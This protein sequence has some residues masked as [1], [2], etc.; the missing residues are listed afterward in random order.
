MVNGM[1]VGPGEPEEIST[2]IDN[3]RSLFLRP[4][5]VLGGL[6]VPKASDV[7][8][9]ELRRQI[10]DGVLPEGAALP[11]ERDLAATSGLSRT[12]VREALRILEIDGLVQT[13]PGRAGGSFVRRPD[14]SSMARSVGA[15][16]AG[17]KVKFRALL[18]VREALEPAG[19][20]LAATYRDDDD[21]AELDNACQRL[22]ESFDDVSGFLLRNLEW[23]VAVVH[24]SHNDLMDAFIRSLSQAIL[25]GTEIEDFYS[26]TTRE[27]TA[28]AHRKVVAAIRDGDAGKARRTMTRHVHAYRVEVESREVPEE[29][30]LSTDGER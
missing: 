27:L 24:A 28:A 30:F 25:H 3:V 26:E 17:R 7:L 15:F 10:L 5:L 20:E 1:G 8:A 11:V 13:R 12:A 9:D 29:L 16:V 21:L 22:E 19:A 6:R 14:A 18:E 23:H 2:D 4:G